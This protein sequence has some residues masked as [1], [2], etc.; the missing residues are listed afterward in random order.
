M[1][2]WVFQNNQVLGPYEPDDL[3]HLPSYSGEAL[4]CPE[5]RKGTN[6]G[7]WQR[8]CLVSELSVSLVKA[9]ELASALKEP[10]GAGACGR[11]PPEHTLK[12][13]AALGSLQEKFSLLEGTVSQL[14]EELRL[15]EGEV[16]SLQKEFNDKLAQAQELALKVGALEEKL[17]SAGSWKESLDKVSASQDDFLSTIKRQNETIEEL[18]R[19]MAE[20]KAAPPPV[21]TEP[22][23]AIGAPALMSFEPASGAQSMETKAFPG[24]N[25]PPLTPTLPPLTG[26]ARAEESFAPPKP[27]L[28][29]PMG[30]QTSPVAPKKKGGAKAALAAVS[31]VTLLAGG[32]LLVNKRPK[33]SAEPQTLPEGLQTLGKE[34]DASPMPPATL[35]AAGVHPPAPQAQQ[36]EADVDQQKQAAVEVVKTWPLPDASKTVGETLEAAAPAG[37]NLSP[38]LAEK[39]KEDIFQVNFYATSGEGGGNRP[40]AFEVHLGDKKVF[41]QN[42][43]AQEILSG[44]V[45]APK[46]LKA[47]PFQAATPARRRTAREAPRR[48]LT[49][50]EDAKKSLDELL[51]PGAPGKADFEEPSQAQPPKPATEKKAAGGGED[52]LL[53]EVLKP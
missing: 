8:A 42:A 53:D 28:P 15:K 17:S 2:Y 36:P 3:S 50:K 23:P 38:W 33:K 12:D 18:T 13:L 37:G 51:L 26:P 31:V 48:R 41:A 29:E 49:K 11:L 25:L 20:L 21:P 4:V 40:Y 7:D 14:Q 22:A 19:K 39:I 32:F 24:P 45:S 9:R 43:A 34:I 47:S 5:G 6:M 46:V 1:R 44:K 10:A 35:D 30:P 16:H 27:Q 52:E